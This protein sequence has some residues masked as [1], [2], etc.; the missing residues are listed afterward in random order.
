MMMSWRSPMEFQRQTFRLDENSAGSNVYRALEWSAQELRGVKGRKGV[1]V[2]TDGVDN[3]LSRKLVSFDRNG[4]PSITPPENDAD[5]QK[6]LRTVTGSGPVYF[7]AVNTDLNPDPASIPNAFDAMQHKAARV[8]MSIV[9]NRSNGVLLLPQ[10]I[11]DV[12]ALYEKIGHE[13]GYAYTVGFNPK[14]IL[15]DGSFHKI[16]IRPADKTLQVLTSRDG[17]Y[18]Q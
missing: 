16:E 7:V 11:E 14:T 9:A 13:L 1:I 2:F 8:R 12:A 5:F 10:K 18:A 3:L 6:M 4:T 15:H 17:Y